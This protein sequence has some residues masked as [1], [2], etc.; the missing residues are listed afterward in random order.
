MANPTPGDSNAP[1]LLRLTHRGGKACLSGGYVFASLFQRTR[2]GFHFERSHG[3]AHSDKPEVGRAPFEL[4]GG[5]RSL[6]GIARGNV[7]AHHGQK[8]GNLRHKL[9]VDFDKILSEPVG[10]HVE[11]F[12]VNHSTHCPE[13]RR[14]RKE[15]E[16]KNETAAK[17]HNERIREGRQSS[18]GPRPPRR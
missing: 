16:E 17:E 4:M 15:G 14:C 11:L 8:S 10:N 3:T 7:L 18:P 9:V 6:Q 12:P 13:Q 1:P 5:T 2:L